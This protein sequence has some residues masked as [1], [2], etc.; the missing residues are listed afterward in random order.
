MAIEALGQVKTIKMQSR[1]LREVPQCRVLLPHLIR[2]GYK[3]RFAV[4]KLIRSPLKTQIISENSSTSTIQTLK[5]C[6]TLNNL[7]F[8]LQFPIHRNQQK[9][10]PEVNDM[11]VVR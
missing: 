8:A 3:A 5:P 6:F 10:P 4:I 1:C 9:S 11:I 7:P 2:N